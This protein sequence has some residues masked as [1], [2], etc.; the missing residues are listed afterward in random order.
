VSQRED[1]NH[2]RVRLRLSGEREFLIAS[3]S[4]AELDRHRAVEEVAKSDAVWLFVARAEA[5]QPDFALTSDNAVAVA[6]IR[7]RL[8][9]LP[10][11]I[12]LAAARSVTGELERGASGG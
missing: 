7:R 9:G 8:D 11:A 3:L 2:Q 6:E 4:L 1:A 5:V 12:E 10:L